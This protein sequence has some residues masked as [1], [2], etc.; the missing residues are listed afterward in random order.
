[1]PKANVK[2]DTLNDKQ[3]LTLEISRRFLSLARSR[4]ISNAFPD[5]P[6]SD[7]F[8][9]KIELHQTRSRDRNLMTSYDWIVIGGGITGAALAYE[10]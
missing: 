3:L 7:L 4:S 9:D 2:T 5:R 8:R 6:L 10:L 1:M